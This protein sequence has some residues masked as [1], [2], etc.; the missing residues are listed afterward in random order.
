MV[1]MLAPGDALLNWPLE[2]RPKKACSRKFL[3]EAQVRGFQPVMAH[4]ERYPYWHG[5][6]HRFGDL[7][8]QG[9]WLQVNAASLAGAYGPEVQ[10]AAETCIDNGWVSLL[11]TDA[12]GLRH[13]DA[14]A[15][16]RVRPAVHRLAETARNTSLF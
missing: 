6:L 16:S 13:I 7:A 10:Q 8:N 11:G 4:I 9:V 14:L 15:A 12:L 3:F 1:M 2:P 5:E